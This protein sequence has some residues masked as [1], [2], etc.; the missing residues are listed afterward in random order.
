MRR[1]ANRTKDSH[2]PGSAEGIHSCQSEFLFATVNKKGNCSTIPPPEVQRLALAR[3]H[4]ATL[5][6]SPLDGEAAGGVTVCVLVESLD[7]LDPSR[8]LETL[9]TRSVSYN[10]FMIERY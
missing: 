6:F 10:I 4:T 3:A 9:L 5:I 1:Q 8:A 7:Y 2:Q